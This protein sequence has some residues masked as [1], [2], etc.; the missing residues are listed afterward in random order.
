MTPDP[1]I[2]A[3]L[4]ALDET[5]YLPPSGTASD[6]NAESALVID[7]ATEGAELAVDGGDCRIGHREIGRIFVRHGD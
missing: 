4:K 3:F 6:L 5:Q 2:A 7:S 1:R